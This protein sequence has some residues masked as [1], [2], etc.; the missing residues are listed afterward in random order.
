M[1]NK[2]LKNYIESS[3]KKGYSKEQ[4][5]SSLIKQGYG[6]KEIDL[7]LNTKK[8]ILRSIIFGVIVW[9]FIV[10]L[11]IGADYYIIT[12]NW[13]RELLKVEETL[14][15]NYQK[16]I[17]M[18]VS[19]NFCN[20]YETLFGMDEEDLRYQCKYMLEFYV[21]G[22]EDCPF[23]TSNRAVEDCISSETKDINDCRDL[24]EPAKSE[25]ISRIAIEQNNSEY[26]YEIWLGRAKDECFFDIA[27]NTSNTGLCNEIT[28]KED[29]EVYLY[30]NFDNCIWEINLGL[31]LA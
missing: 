30:A 23:L 24:T 18:D 1:V 21:R 12:T 19:V 17:S 8:R 4:I 13:D 7:A 11:F 26:C 22:I 3:L 6:Q 16:N 15:Y 20:H 5:K 9:V 25:C 28:G 27:I 31:G 10:L 14:F 29:E 2:Q